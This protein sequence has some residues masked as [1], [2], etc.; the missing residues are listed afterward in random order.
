[1][2]S[3]QLNALIQIAILVLLLLGVEIK[4]RQKLVLHGS[5]MLGAVTLNLLSFV[6]I[7]LPSLLRTEIISTQP[8]HVISIVTLIHS[9]I[10]LLV[11]ILGIWLMFSWR[12][13]SSPVNCFKFRRLMRW[14]TILWLVALLMGFL[15]Y[16]FLYAY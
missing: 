8:L 14:T 7:M 6:F 5:M 10:G 12:L 2:I 16:Y 4:R 15:L 1:M 13:R 9:S 3:P 11:M